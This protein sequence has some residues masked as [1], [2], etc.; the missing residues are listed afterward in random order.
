MSRRDAGG[1]TVLPGYLLARLAIDRS[2]RGRGLGAQLL[3]DALE[4]IAGG[5]GELG[6]RIIVVDPID[7]E[8]AAFYAHYGF[9]D[10]QGD[11]RRMYMKI[12]SVRSILGS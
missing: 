6:G 10:C 2:I 9:T 7:D 1:N 12:A 5:A 8:A 11:R 3:L 4:R